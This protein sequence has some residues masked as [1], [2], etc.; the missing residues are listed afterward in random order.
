M[1]RFIYNSFNEFKSA[2]EATGAEFRSYDQPLSIDPDAPAPNII[3][4]AT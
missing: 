3:R 1:K 2:I 4:F